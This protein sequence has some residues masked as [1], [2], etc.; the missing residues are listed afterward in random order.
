MKKILENTDTL[1]EVFCTHRFEIKLSV[2]LSGL[3]YSL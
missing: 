2:K 1:N 3:I